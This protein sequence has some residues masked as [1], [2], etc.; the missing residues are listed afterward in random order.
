ME[1]A[2]RN[3]AHAHISPCRDPNIPAKRVFYVYP[4]LGIQN[5]VNDGVPFTGIN[6]AFRMDIP[7]PTGLHDAPT[8]AYRHKC[9]FVDEAFADPQVAVFVC[10][11]RTDDDDSNAAISEAGNCTLSSSGTYVL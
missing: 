3:R 1:R 2:T 4:Q 8:A 6:R 9:L 5:A 11:G 7:L 10:S